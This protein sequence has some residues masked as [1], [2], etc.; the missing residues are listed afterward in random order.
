M[1]KRVVLAG[2]VVILGLQGLFFAGSESSQA[3]PSN[4]NPDGIL[5]YGYDLNDQFDGTF[6]PEG[7]TNGCAYAILSNIYQSVASPGNFSIGGGAAESWTVSN[8]DSTVTFHLRPNLH[9]S[10]GAPVTSSDVEASLAYIKQS[11][12]RTSLHPI[13]SMSTP[14]PET[15]VVNLS[16]ATA[17]DFLWAMTY[18]DGTVMEASNIPNANA[19]P[20]GSGPFKLHSYQQGSSVQLVK[21]PTYYDAGKYPLGGVDF[22]NVAPG[23]EAVTALTSG[24]V[25]M[26]Q[27]EPENVPELKSNPN[28]GLA[29]TK[30][31]DY[32]DIIPRQN[33]GPFTNAKVRAALEYAVNRRV[34]N[35][36]L[37][38]GL[39]QPAYQP[40]PS[41]SPGY[42]KSLGNF[43]TYQ[44]AKAKAMLRAAGFP[45]G[46]K[47]TM[48]F[49]AGDATY[50]RAAALLQQELAQAGFDANLLQI[51]GSDYLVDVY[52]KGE[53]DAIL[54]L[55]RST[56]P[57]IASTYGS[58]FEASGFQSL[59]LGL[60][61]SQITALVKQA[62]TSLSPSVEGPAMQKAAQLALKQGLDI[63]LVFEPSIIAYNKQRVGGN[64]VPP[65]GQCRS[66][67][68]G[69]YIK[70]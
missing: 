8:D 11:A 7:T 58:M 28:I 54:S 60:V 46:V 65:I 56:G 30:S 49:P 66:N 19:H 15:L 36:V 5:K 24:A 35:Q 69:I 16:G 67:L 34:L 1:I 23:P 3:A 41:W 13:V 39:G 26:V 33:S 37:L 53:G 61:N 63:P 47:F 22:V 32:M 17:G 21:N 48:V 70:K 40:W 62:N 45:K 12:Q 42:N 10:N 64:V 4:I 57:D 51:P 29:M 44:P 52:I 9:F 38:D 20:I 43:D 50:S 68:A 14:D 18:L 6:D 2:A 59:K 55:E 27:V 25:D 31:Y